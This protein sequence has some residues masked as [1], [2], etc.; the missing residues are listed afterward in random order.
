MDQNFQAL[1]ERDHHYIDGQWVKGT[2]EHLTL[3]DPYTEQ[4]FGRAP[5]G[6]A[7]LV[8]QAVA[9]AIHGVFLTQGRKRNVSGNRRRAPGSCGASAQP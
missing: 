3:I 5:A 9:A 8:D 1:C 6:D 2:G 4:P 7:A